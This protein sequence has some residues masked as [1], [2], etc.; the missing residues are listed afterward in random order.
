MFVVYRVVPPN[1]LVDLGYNQGVRSP[2]FMIGLVGCRSAYQ[3]EVCVSAAEFPWRHHTVPAPADH[4]RGQKC[5]QLAS[6]ITLGDRRASV[7]RRKPAMAASLGVAWALC[8]NVTLRIL[9]NCPDRESQTMTPFSFSRQLTQ[10][11]RDYQQYWP[12]PL[13]PVPLTFF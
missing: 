9:T 10:F 6:M 12:L 8:R 11:C 13:L 1:K 5:L 4:H 7:P 2:S 3:G